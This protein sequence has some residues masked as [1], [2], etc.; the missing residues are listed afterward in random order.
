MFATCSFQEFN[1]A[2]MGGVP[3]QSSNGF[4]RHIAHT[5]PYSLKTDGLVHKLPLTFPTPVA[6]IKW[7]REKFVPAYFAHLEEVGVDAI[8]E[9]AKHLRSA[10]GVD[11]NAVL[12]LLCFEQLAKKPGTYCHRSLFA[13][14][15]TK[16]TGEDVPEYG[17]VRPAET[18]AEEQ[19]LF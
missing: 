13:Q 16:Q 4:P 12:V 5:L 15:W 10:I 2:L 3:V 11:E 18:R 1:P 8:R 17:A 19:G 14:W 7:P 6:T 9:S